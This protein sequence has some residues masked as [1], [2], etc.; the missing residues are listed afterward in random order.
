MI[1]IYG[2]YTNAVVYTTNNEEYAIDETI[3]LCEDDTVTFIRLTMLA[4][5]I[6]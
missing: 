5:R 1:K 4:G 2:K 6:W 3:N